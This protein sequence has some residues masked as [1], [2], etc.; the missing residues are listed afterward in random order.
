M[1][2]QKRIETL[3][4]LSCQFFGLKAMSPQKRIETLVQ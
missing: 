1:S 4:D 3:G 2:P